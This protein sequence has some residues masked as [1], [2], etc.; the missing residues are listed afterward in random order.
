MR[1]HRQEI[2]DVG[3]TL[4]GLVA[5]PHQPRAD[6]VAVG[7][8][9]DQDGA[10]CCSNRARLAL[11]VATHRARLQGAAGWAAASW[12][13]A[14]MSASI[15]VLNGS[16]PRAA[17]LRSTAP[18]N[19]EMVRSA[20]AAA[21]SGAMPSGSKW[22]TSAARHRANTL[23]NAALNS[24]SWGASPRTMVAIAQPLW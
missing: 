14:L 23:S 13:M 7:V 24:A 10:E 21:R 6:R 9:A 20:R 16:M 17:R 12:S 2:D 22:V 1:I 19:A 3:P 18:S 4:T 11:S 8:V 15:V 5:V